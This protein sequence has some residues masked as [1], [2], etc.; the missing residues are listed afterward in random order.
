MNFEITLGIN[1]KTYNLKL[2]KHITLQQIVKLLYGNNQGIVLEHNKKI[3]TIN[4]WDKIYIESNDRIE[5][6]T[7][8][9]GG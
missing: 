2:K 8:V 1:G 9:G 4:L 3:L 7:I 6:L 5:I